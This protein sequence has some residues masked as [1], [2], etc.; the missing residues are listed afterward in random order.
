MKQI[1]AFA[2]ISVV[3]LT[4]SCQKEEKKV[5]TEDNT[6][7]ASNPF[8]KA[9]ELPFQAPDFN[10][11]KDS[12]FQPAM[13]AGMKE[14]LKEIEAIVSNPE[15]ATFENTFIPLEKSGQL[16]NRVRAV[17]GLLSSANTNPELQA[18]QETQA[19]KFAAHR[20]A[21]YLNPEL[22]K[23]V[24][25]L[26][27]TRETLNLD[28]ESSHLIE[29]YYQRFILSG[30]NLEEAEKT[31]LKKLNGEVAS[32]SAKF[33]NQLLAA[34]KAGALVVD[35]KE[36]LAGLSD[37]EIDAAANEDKTQWTIPL[38][39]TTQQPDLQNLTNRDTREKLFKN[40]WTRAEQ[41]DE[42]DT[43][44][45]IERIAEIR[46]EQ[47]SI[48]GFKT[49]AEWKL[50]DQMAKTPEAVLDFLGQLIPAATAKAKSEA[51]DIQALIDSQN[52]G[53]KLEDWD[54]NLYSEQVRKARYDLDESQ[55]KPYFELYNVLENGVFY[56]AN[57]L[58]G[59]TF[60]E[61]KD[62]PVYQ[63]DVR[64][65]DVMDKDGSQIG[66]FYGD[67]FK[68]D[69]KSGGAWMSNLI[70]QSKLLGTQP[71]IY[72]VC[73]YTKPAEGQPA[74][75]SFDDVTTL[76]HEFGHALHGFF[77]DQQYVSLSG[78][79]TPRDFVEFPSQFNEHW[80]LY[81]SILKNYAFHY[82]TGEAMPQ[83]LIDK[84]K[85]AST[86]N[87]GYALTEALSAASLDM[88]WHTLTKEDTIEDADSFEKAALIRTHL[89]LKEVPPR[90]RSSYFLH[91]WSNGYAA[92]YYA[93]LWTEMLDNDAFAWFEEN[94][95]LTPENGQRFRDMILSRGNTE[96]FGKLYHDFRGQEPSIEPLLK[97]RSLK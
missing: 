83:T 92:G 59:L 19:P 17:F 1:A 70:E 74:L 9:S 79:N 61:R 37:A 75:I 30:A 60:K 18:I 21:I 29:Y 44:K 89:N 13:D 34:A 90:Y 66:L 97:N 78:T 91:I 65:Y 39:N 46:A 47:A 72:N 64:V 52:G 3:I 41:G 2:L 62:L 68:R 26:Y 96:A 56:A 8:A 54:W 94:G 85:K 25:T 95:G 73:N 55:I 80:A 23:R 71:V 50:Q 93:Y 4:T 16:L 11:I 81:P 51:A 10:A 14:Q 5:V 33:T 7:L 38:Q 77:A 6:L 69:N 53:F 35:N 84:I 31:K 20:D 57:Q 86:F 82:K 15:P 48:L 45:T 87:Q 49:Y 28:A 88:E 36:A 22:F 76:F 43:R 63:E 32:L 24:E 27:N 12:D 42:N 67:Y 40:S 58:Y